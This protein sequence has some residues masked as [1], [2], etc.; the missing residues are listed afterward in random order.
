MKV[1]KPPFVVEASA[2]L[3]YPESTLPGIGVPLI[4]CAVLYAIPRTS[5]LGAILVTGYLAP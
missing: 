2:P 1:L 5:V 3:A 4:I